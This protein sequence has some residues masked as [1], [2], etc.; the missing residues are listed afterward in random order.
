MGPSGS[1]QRTKPWGRESTSQPAGPS[2]KEGGCPHS[3]VC[4]L[5]GTGRAR[6]RELCPVCV[7][8]FLQ[9]HLNLPFVGAREAGFAWDCSTQTVGTHDLPPGLPKVPP[10]WGLTPSCK[11]YESLNPSFAGAVR[12]RGG[13]RREAGRRAHL[14]EL[15]EKSFAGTGTA[16][17]Q[18]PQDPPRGQLGGSPG[19]RGLRKE[20]WRRLTVCA[21]TFHLPRE[22]HSREL[23]G[24]LCLQE[25]DS[26]PP[27]QSGPRAP[28]RQQNHPP[29]RRLFTASNHC[30]RGTNVM[31]AG[32]GMS[33]HR[34]RNGTA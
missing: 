16:R 27:S 6:S 28:T 20:A 18:T 33:C 7:V 14:E 26:L 11:R 30:S 21:P 19:S 8:F 32:I 3:A 2:W 4:T 13:T 34:H 22:G 23:P 24:E 5:P 15:A 12:A 17:D 31:V 9:K 29:A 1:R 10:D 25:G